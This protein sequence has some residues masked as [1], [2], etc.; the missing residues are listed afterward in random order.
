MKNVP[1]FRSWCVLLAASALV[2][3]ADPSAPAAAAPAPATTTLPA[4][5]TPLRPDHVMSQAPEAPL[6]GVDF[7]IGDPEA[8][9][10]HTMEIQAEQRAA[11]ATAQPGLQSEQDQRAASENNDWMLRDY[12]ARLKQEG[13]AQSADT[14]PTTFSQA[15]NPLATASTA[16]ANV[17]PL[18][19]PPAPA[20]AAPAARSP[21]SNGTKSEITVSELPPPSSAW[22][23]LQPLLPPLTSPAK[24][25]LDAW[26]S[27]PIFVMDKQVVL[28][29]SATN[30]NSPASSTL[31]IPGLTAAENGMGPAAGDL[32]VQDPLPDDSSNRTRPLSDRNIFLV[33]AAPMSDMAEFFKKQSQSLGAPNAPTVVQP[34]GVPLAPAQ[35]ARPAE[36]TAKPAVSGLRSHVDDPFDILRQ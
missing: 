13:L 14:D 3:R 23:S 12:T 4:P 35:P 18:L 10:Q 1:D 28:P 33:P 6:D 8:V 16:D 31:D 32:N 5:S 27:E 21:S 22:T 24:A 19:N 9:A 20:K 29:S 25:P 2:A 34:V 17:D 15:A 36:P 26:G 11:A 30:E 7:S